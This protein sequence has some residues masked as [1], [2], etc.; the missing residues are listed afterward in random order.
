MKT[1]GNL[2]VL[3]VEDEPEMTLLV[4]K[5]LAKKVG[6]SVEAV[7][8]LHSALERLRGDYPPIDVVLLDLNLPDAQGLVALHTI[9]KEFPLIPVVVMTGSL[10]FSATDCLLAGAH[11]FILKGD[12][13][14][15]MD[16]ALRFAVSRHKVRSAFEPL[17]EMMR[18]VRE[19]IE[20][21]P[22][23]GEA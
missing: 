3:C 19:H 17:K 7:G 15:G 9:V 23:K 12:S 21:P 11:D 1:A 8:S 6:F 22:I 5:W 10:E 14:E 18:E 4:Q 2:L 16:R 13:L 20:N